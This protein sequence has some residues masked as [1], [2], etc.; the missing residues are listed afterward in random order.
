MR[1]LAS[2]TAFDKSSEN[3]FERFHTIFS[4]GK[5]DEDCKPEIDDRKK[6]CRVYRQVFATA[7][8]VGLKPAT[9]RLIVLGKHD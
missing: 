7:P 8:Q 9:Y 4:C 3:Q 1:A 6:F 2:F 5:S